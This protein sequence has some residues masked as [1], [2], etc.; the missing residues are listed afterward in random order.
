MA[1]ATKK[2]TPA[3]NPRP[4]HRGD[5]KKLTGVLGVLDAIYRFLASLK[6]A[7][8]SISTLALV[9]AYATFYESWY[10]TAAV[11]ERVYQ[12]PGFYL[13]L[14]FL[15]TNILCA[16]L[17]RF[18]WTKRQTGFVITHAGLLTLI[19]GSWWTLKY[20]DEGMVGM[21]EGET[22]S[23]LVRTDYPVIRVRP[24]DA[25]TGAPSREYEVPFR[26]GSFAWPEGRY[27]ILTS[28]RDPFQLA[29]KAYYPASA[30][31]MIT[32]ADP[33]GSPSLRIRPQFKPPGSNQFVDVFDDEERWFRT[34]KKLYRATRTRSASGPMPAQFSFQY[35]D[36]PEMVEDFLNPPTNLGPTGTAR[37]RYKD[38]EGK[39]KF[40]D[41]PIDESV[42]EPN[43]IL[44]PDSDLTATYVKTVEFSAAEAGLSA[45]VGPGVIHVAEFEVKK[46]DGPGVVHYGWG[47]LP[48][49]PN[50]IP[51]RQDET[52]QA[53]EPLVSINY[54][55]PPEFDAGRM[56]L[57][58]V[59]VIATPQ[60]QLY[61]R[62]F[63]RGKQAGETAIR[64][65]GPLQL[66]REV[67]AFGGDNMPMQ[68]TFTADEYL[69]AGVEKQICV[70]I[71]LP[72]G[73]M[74][75]GIPAALAEL[76]VDGK[77]EEFWVRPGADQLV[78][79]FRPIDF[80]PT[81]YEVAFD[82]DRK[83]LGF[84]VVLD[85]FDVGFDPGTEQASSFESKVRVTDPEEK[86]KDKP[87][88]ISMNEPMVHRQ[89]TFYQSSY[90]RA[91]DPRTGRETGQFKSVFQVGSDPGRAIKYLGSL[92]ICVGTFVQFY[93][94]AGV[95]T[96]ANKGKAKAEKPAADEP[97]ATL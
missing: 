54:Y 75:N 37:L 23:Q 49:V 39:P 97:E 24:L 17:I 95:F 84:E 60:K 79:L 4:G 44:L 77:T 71:E 58:A 53:P 3:P 25:Q 27:E 36:R 18:P 13:L 9:L 31:K 82:V 70:P 19:F 50:T 55:L 42:T 21:L 33:E 46:G 7:V 63:G 73:Q 40:Y 56:R 14:L 89:W 22:S 64:S 86:V 92:M 29:I 61:Y 85:D 8:I 51:T 47:M 32:V 69:E 12:H 88:T 57:G 93:M 45:M 66:G 35:V 68:I 91:V 52:G 30:P 16:A 38:R 11:Q 26:P 72:K 34:D 74:G 90:I 1:T 10:G 5:G 83:P 28:K 78:P 87:V 20:A 6:L 80:G 59:E 62:V 67:L 65:S 81:R 96:N 15:G 2:P 76:T 48:M 41:W 43:T 94:K